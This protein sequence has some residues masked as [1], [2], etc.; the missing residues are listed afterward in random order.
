MRREIRRD[1]FVFELVAGLHDF[2]EEVSKGEN[3]VFRS[4]VL[5]CEFASSFKRIPDNFEA[6][7]DQIR[8]EV[9]VFKNQVN[10]LG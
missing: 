1:Y 2:N 5:H 7:F 8:R 10:L 9:I 4:K 3:D 6:Y